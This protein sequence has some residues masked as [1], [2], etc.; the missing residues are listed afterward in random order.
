VEP[1]NRLV[2]RTLEKRWEEKLRALEKA[3]QEFQSWEAKQQ[4]ALTPADRETLLSLGMN[5]PEVWHAG[6]TTPADCKQIIRLV[7]KEVI[8]DQKRARGKV[9]FQVN[10]QTG[11]SSQHKYV[12]RV[13]AYDQH[14][15]IDQIQQRIRELHAKGKF[16][17]EIAAVLNAEGF[18]TTKQKLFNNKKIWFLRKRMGFPPVKTHGALPEQWEDG[19]YSVKGAAKVI[20]V[21]PDTIFTWLRTGL[22]D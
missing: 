4:L 13:S 10:W 20:G 8:V 9:W 11:A 2:A 7:I 17:T 15:Y 1:E 22:D 21:F 12:R 3:E 5:L 6:S 19:C 14:A 16:D 18:L